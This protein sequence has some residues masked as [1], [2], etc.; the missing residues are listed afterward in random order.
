MP[1]ESHN[2]L[3]FH[4]RVLQWLALLFH[5]KRD[6]GLN[7]L[8]IW[9]G[10]IEEDAMSSHYLN[11]HDYLF[12]HVFS[13]TEEAPFTFDFWI[14]SQCCLDIWQNHLQRG[15]EGSNH[16]LNAL[17]CRTHLLCL[18]AIACQFL[19]YHMPHLYRHRVAK[20]EMT[21]GRKKRKKRG[22]KRKAK[23]NE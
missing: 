7:L 21:G 8:V 17:L 4:T 2:L 5:S 20:P 10:Y 16:G 23:E 12:I 3:F 9:R 18:L 19:L 11:T 14:K 22:E 13:K 6:L 15:L 1:L